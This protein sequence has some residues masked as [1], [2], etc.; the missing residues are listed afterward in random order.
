M[1]NTLALACITL[2]AFI[3]DANAQCAIPEPLC[4]QSYWP[5]SNGGYGLGP[6]LPV[7]G[8]A[9]TSDMTSLRARVDAAFTAFGQVQQQAD[10]A[11][12]V[13][14]IA[15]AMR[16][17]IPNHGDRFALRVNAAAM[18]GRMAGSI[19][20]SMNISDSTRLSINYGRGAT[21]NIISGGMNFSFK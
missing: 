11:L 8:F 19:G 17:A 10:T 15:A 2:A 9:S 18:D 16:D 21:Q 4:I 3:S 1:K 7:S 12:E 14:T 20:A 5:A 6:W 13:A